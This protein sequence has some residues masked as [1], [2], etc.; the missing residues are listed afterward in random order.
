MT[1]PIEGLRITFDTTLESPPASVS[2]EGFRF[3]VDT[4]ARITV[5]E[6]RAP[7]S[8]GVFIMTTTGASVAEAVNEASAQVVDG[9]YLVQILSLG[10][11]CYLRVDGSIETFVDGG[12]RV[13]Q[14]DSDSAAL[15]VR[16]FQRHPEATIQTTEQPRDIMRAISCLGSALKTNSPE[17]SWPSLRGCPPLITVDGDSFEAPSGLERTDTPVHIE[18]PPTLDHIYP[19]V[20]LAYYLNATVVPGDTPLLVADGVEHSL[21]KTD[22]YEETV[23]RTLEQLFTLDCVTR[24]EGLYPLDLYERSVI[25][26]RVGF[27][28]SRLYDAD[29]ATQVNTYLSVPWDDIADVRPGWKLTADVQPKARH[30]A[31]L[32]FAAYDLAHIRVPRSSPSSTTIDRDAVS[33]LSEFTRAEPS[34]TVQEFQSSEAAQPHIVSPPPVE[35][36]EHAWIGEGVPIGASKPTA[37]ACERRLDPVGDGPVSVQVIANAPEMR[38]ERSVS[39]IY[40]L[41]EFIEMDV[42]IHEEQTVSETRDLLR[43]EHDLLHYIGHVT[44]DGLQCGDGFLDAGTLSNVGMRAFILNACRSY[45]Q[46]RALVDAGAVGGVVTLSTVANAPAT[47]VG[48]Q[49][50]RLLNAGFSLGG[51]LDVIGSETTTGRQYVI[52]GDGNTAV[53]ATSD[54]TALRYD[55]ERDGETF[56]LHYHGYPSRQAPLGATYTPY[57]G[58]NETFYLNSGHIASIEADSDDLRHLLQRA[59]SV[60]VRFEGTLYWSDVVAAEDVPF[61]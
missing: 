4:A 53:T 35:S 55:V 16:S 49:I 31:F 52:V 38:S 20:S 21:T 24:T 47:T 50:A 46:G 56:Q 8:A 14:F 34:T 11:I 25:E 30:A 51:A 26:R 19:I 9:E 43:S 18:V 7:K 36:I 29:L 28:F 33:A 23:R 48:R 5:D 54:G 42:T 58:S 13:I 2:T 27:D 37:A 3:P 60:P 10:I 32:P 61:L 44:E 41:R 15:G 45:G 6:L 17:R 40:G 12:E 1:D 22:D 57:L 39:D 59:S